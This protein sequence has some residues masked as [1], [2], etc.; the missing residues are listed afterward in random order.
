MKLIR[1]ICSANNMVYSVY[2]YGE[3]ERKYIMYLHTYQKTKNINYQI[4]YILNNYFW[5]HFSVF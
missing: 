4:I 2:R 1:I 3:S 5:T